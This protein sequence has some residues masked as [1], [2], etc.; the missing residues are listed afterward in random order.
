MDNDA[1]ELFGKE[2]SEDCSSSSSES[3]SSDEAAD[4][5][6]EH[7]LRGA[8]SRWERSRNR[9]HEGVA[10]PANPT[11][12]VVV[13]DSDGD[14]KSAKEEVPDPMLVGVWALSLDMSGILTTC[15]THTGLVL[16]DVSF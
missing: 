5:S 7:V 6:V 13:D 15:Q 4:D 10:G 14:A 12:P 2:G 3:S 1:H 9:G 11:I 8:T 16:K